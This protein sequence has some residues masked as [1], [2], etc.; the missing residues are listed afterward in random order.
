MSFKT[1]RFREQTYKALKWA[2]ENT[3]L[4]LEEHS[5]YTEYEVLKRWFARRGVWKV[6]DVRLAGL[7][8]YGWMPT[9][10][11]AEGRNKKPSKINFAS[12]AERLNRGD[13]PPEYWNFLNNSYVGTSKFL[14]FWNPN[15]FAVWDSRIHGVFYEKGSAENLQRITDYQDDMRAFGQDLRETEFALFRYAKSDASK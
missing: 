11:R 2:E 3:E 8:I 15:R 1:P 5:Y 9:I 10:L 6:E 7:A 14:H 4:S 13:L 12:I